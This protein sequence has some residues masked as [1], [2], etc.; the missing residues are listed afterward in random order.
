MKSATRNTLTPLSY[1]QE[2]LEFIDRFETGAVYESSPI[3][4]NIPLAVRFA[5]A[6]DADLLQQ[7]LDHIM[8][9]HKVLSTTFV[10]EGVRAFQ[11]RD[12]SLGVSLQIRELAAE[13]PG[14]DE[15]Q[16]LRLVLEE[17]EV[18]FVLVSRPMIRATLFRRAQ[19]E[20]LLVLVAHHIIVDRFSMRL[21]VEE[22][23]EIYDSLSSG[24]SPNLS[25]AGLPYSDYAEWQQG[26]AAKD[27][28][29]Y[30]MYWKNRLGGE[31]VDL[32]L[33]VRCPRHAMHIY[34]GAVHRFSIPADLAQAAQRLSARYQ[35]GAFEFLFACFYALLHRYSAQE[36]FLVGITDPCRG[37]P[38]TENAIGPF[39]NLLALDVKAGAGAFEE[40]LTSAVTNVRLA[41][42][43]RELPFDLLVQRLKLTNDM[44]RTAL[45]DV[46]FHYEDATAPILTF[47]TLRGKILETNLG[48][49]KYD[50]NL[51]LQPGAVGLSA[52][53]AYN[54]LLYNQSTIEQLARHFLSL[55]VAAVNAPGIP[56]GAVAL[57]NEAERTQQIYGWNSTTAGYPREKTIH[58]LIEERVCSQPNE[59]ALKYGDH[60]LTFAELNARANQLAHWLRKQGVGPD[61]MVA[62]CLERTLEMVVA[63]LA[64]L[65][66]G[67]GYLPLD[68]LYPEE[69]MRFIMED[70]Q[71][72]HLITQETLATRL[73]GRVRFITLVDKDQPEI[74]AQATANVVPS[75]RPANLAYCIYTSGST[76]KPNGVLIEH[77]QVV[78]LIKNDRFYF[79]FRSSDV[80]TLFHS[81]CFDF[82]VWE[83]FCSLSYG[84]TLVIVPREIAR[85][86]RLFLELLQ[87]ERVTVLNQTPA[88][89]YN[90]AA[91]AQQHPALDLALRYVI[92]G[93]EALQPAYLKQWK[94]ICPDSKLINMYGITETTVHVT[95]REVTPLD[96]EENTSNIGVPIPTT[97]TYILDAQMELAP[98]G[99]K[100]EIY[101]GGAGLARGYLNRSGLTAAR[102]VP[103][104]LNQVNGPR[105]YR[106]GDLAR[107]LSDGSIEYLGRIDHQVKLRGYRI[108]LGEIETAL[109]EL[110]GVERA[111]VQLREDS[112]GQKHLVAYV[113]AKDKKGRLEI[114]RL[115]RQLREK[116]PEYMAPG[117]FMELASVPLTP[118]GKV[119]HKRLPQPQ[120]N[121]QESEFAEPRNVQEEILCGIFAEILKRERVGVHDNF[122]E[123]G[124]HSLLATPVI[125][126]I[127]DVFKVE[128]PLRTL[129]EGPTVAALS[130]YIDRH[131]GNILEA[132]PIKRVSREGRLPLSFAQERLWFLDQLEPGSAAYNMPFGVRLRGELNEEALRRSVNEIVRRHEALRTSFVLEEG[133]PAQKIGA[134]LEV[135][136]EAINLQGMGDSGELEAGRLARAM[137]GEGFDLGRGPLLQI[138]L[139]RLGEEEHVLLVNMHHIVSDGWSSVIMVREF[140]RLYE[141]YVKG[142][143]SP[144]AELEVQ[145]VDYAVWQ[146]GWLEGE[147][148]E[149]QMGYWRE[150][151]RGLEALELPT[152]YAR[153]AVMSQRGGS[154]ELQLSAPLT[155]KLKELGRRQGATLFMSL[156]GGMQ[157]MLSKYV[158]QHDLAVG[159]VIANRNRTE[160]EGLIGFFVNTLVLRTDLGGNPDFREALKRVRHVALEAY[161]HQDMPFEKLVEE[162]S[163]Q[164]DL[165]RSPLFQVMLVLQNMEQQELQLTGLQVSGFEIGSEAA[166]FDLLL[167]L[168][169]QAG[170]VKGRL[171]YA[172]DLYDETTIERMAGHLRVVLEAMAGSARQKVGSID[173]LGEQE[174]RQILDEW[175][176][177]ERALPRQSVHE[178]FAAQVVRTPAACALSFEGQRLSY[179]ELNRRSSGLA[180]C[181]C[182]MGVGIETRVGLCL[183]RSA[184]MVIGILGI[185]KAGGVYVPLDPDYPA[186]RLSYMLEDS[187]AGVLLLGEGMWEKHAT[188]WAEYK[189]HVL[190][191]KDVAWSSDSAAQGFETGMAVQPE[192]AAYVIYTSGSTGRPKGVVVT[193]GNVARLMEGTERW[194]GFN[195]KDVIPLFHSYGFDFSVWEM[196]SALHYGGRLVVTSYWVSR[197][198]EEFV[199]LLIGEEVTVLNQTPSAFQQLMAAEAALGREWNG[200]GDARLKLR[201]VIFGGEALDYA[202]LRPW[203]ERHGERP[204]LV[205]MYGITETTVHVTYGPIGR[206]KVEEKSVRSAIGAP[207][208]DLKV[209]LLDERRQAAPVGVRGELYVGGAGVARGYLN[210]PE[211]TAER[212]VPNPYAKEAGERLYC[213]GDA[214]SWRTDGS[215]DYYGRL[216]QQVKIRGFRIELGEIEARL[217]EHEGVRE[218]VVVA[219]EDTSGEKRL[220]AYYTPSPVHAFPVVQLLRLRK[221]GAGAAANYCTLPNGL[222]VFHQNQSETD[223]VYDEIFNGD[224]YLRYGVTLNDGDCVFDVGA[225]IGLFSLFVG[226]RCRNATIYAFEPIPPVF[227]SLR[228][229]SRLHGWA[230]KLYECGLAETSKQ[231]VFTFYPHNT[232]ISSSSTN[233]KSYLLKQQEGA[234]VTNGRTV[235]DEGI[236]ELLEARLKSEEYMCQLR[237]VSEIIEENG[238][239]RIDLLKIN[240][241][242]SEHDVLKGIED[243]DWPKIRQLVIEVHDVSGRLGEIV[244]LFEARGYK[245]S[246]EQSRF[247]QHTSLYSLYACRP[248]IGKGASNGNGAG[249]RADA[250]KFWGSPESLLRDMRAFLR[251][252]LPEYMVP[253]AYVP[254]D[255]MPLTANGKLDRKALPAPERESYGQ[256]DEDP[257]G[258]VEKALAEIW[259]TVLQVERVGRHDNFFE[260]GGHSLLAITL[261]ERMRRN[262]LHA[263]VRTLFTTPTLADLAAAIG[264]ASEEVEVPPNRIPAQAEI[265]TPEMLPLVQLTA[266]EIERIVSGVVGG[267]SNV[268]DIYPLA[269]LQEGILFHHLIPAEGDTYLLLGLYGFDTRVRLE[270][271]VSALQ[272]VIDRHD[273]LRTAVVWEGLPEPVQVVWRKAPLIVEEVMF[274]PDMGD[275]AQQMYERF[276]PSRNRIDVRQA[277]LMRAYISHDKVGQRWL[278]LIMLHHLSGDH[279]T[280]EVM[281]SEIQAH[282]QG[283]VDALPAPLPFRNF[284]AQARM[285]VSEEEHKAFFRNMLEDV[286]EPTAPFGLL[287]IKGGDGSKI[288]QYY[289][290][291]EAGLALRL[292]EHARSLGVSV[293]SIFHVAWTLVLARVSGRDDVVFGTVLFGRMQGGEGADRV[294]GLFINTL[295]LRVRVGMEGV[296]ASVRRMHAGLADLIQHEHASLVLAQRCSG[297]AAPT[298]LFSAVLNY[299]YN[300]EAGQVSSG[301]T[302]N[303]WAGVELLHSVERNNYPLTLSVEDLGTDL[304]LSVLVDPL[305]EPMRICAFMHVALERLVEALETVPAQPLRSL[306]ALPMSERR[307]IVEEWNAT[308]QEYE[309]DPCLHELFERQVERTPESVAV[310]YAGQELTYGELDRRANQLGHYLRRMG[311]GPEV[312]VGICVERSLEMVVGMLGILKAGGAYVAL[313]PGYPGERLGY[314]LGDSGASV[315]VTQERLAGQLL[316]K[317]TGQ[318]RQVAVVCLDQEWEEKIGKESGR[319]LEG[320]VG[321]E[322]LSYIYY[323]SGSTGRPKGVAMA[324]RGIVNYMRWG[325]EGYRAREGRGAGVHSSIAVDLTLTNFLPLFVGQRMALAPEGPG[326]EGL[327]EVMK[328]EPGWSLLKITPTHLTLLNPRLTEREMRNS[329]RVLVIGAD[330]LVAEPTLVWREKAPGVMLLNEYG[331]TETVVGCSVYRIGGDAPRRGGMPIGKPIWNMTMYVL[332][333]EG[334]PAPVGVA[335]ELYIG[336]VGVARGYWGKPELTAE[337]FV[338][339]RYAGMGARFYRTGDRARFLRDGNL[340]FLGRVDHQ[341]KIRGY[342]IE[343]E[344]IEAVISGCAGVHKAMVVVREDEPGEKRLVGYVA[345][346]GGVE[347]KELREYLKE[348]LPDYMIPVAFVVLEE[349]PVR[350][351]G[352][353]DPKDLPRPEMVG[354]E[355]S[356]VEARTE[357]ER[358]LARIWEEVLGVERVGVHDNFFELG[359]DSILSLRVTTRAQGEGIQL[360]PLHMFERQTI[361]ELAQVVGSESQQ[362][363]VPQEIV[364]GA[365]ELTP[366]QAAFFEK[367]LAKP[368]HHNQTVLLELREEVS[369]ELLEQLVARLLDQHDGLRMRYKRSENGWQQ[370]YEAQ[371]PAGVYERKMLRTSEEEDWAEM[372]QDIARVQADLDLEAGRLVKVVEYELGAG[373]GKRL[374]LVVHHLLMDEASWRILLEDLERGYEQFKEGQEINLGTKTSS[375]KQWAEW[376]KEQ[377]A[378][379]E[380]RQEMEYWGAEARTR[381]AKRLPWDYEA[382]PEE[383]LYET[384]RMVEVEL[385][386]QEARSLLQDVPGV[387]RTELHEVL[388]AVLGKVCG[389]WTGSDSVL[390]DVEGHGRENVVDGL[391]LSRTIGRFTYMYPLVFEGTDRHGEWK[392]GEALAFVKEDLRAIP[393]HGLG[394]G[395]L[396][397]MSGDE[398]IQQDLKEL[399]QAEISFNYLEMADPVFPESSWFK[400]A[401]EDFVMPTASKNQRPYALEFTAVLSGARLRVNWKYSEK[402]HRRDSIERIA[403][404]YMEILRELIVHCRNEQAGG[405]TPSDFPLARMSAKDLDELAA[406]LD[407]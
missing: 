292:R 375:F 302:E 89:F 293:A 38:G 42:K 364:T 154:V 338:P 232:A 349:L 199:E 54:S 133:E 5:G 148:L 39:S 387:Y 55:M 92:F 189:G 40:F 392:P 124:G 399:P 126:R 9:R 77:S 108:E 347:V 378:T 48:Y 357:V 272:S 324:H 335:G 32:E 194:F 241:E 107:Y 26:L 84:A 260:L 143:E 67:G 278:L 294:M 98:V 114:S 59:I 289:L 322:N 87:R 13:A 164:R 382:S 79:D 24:R 388:L 170:M 65:K 160:T 228:L 346:P 400:L 321:A 277:P 218:A 351:S 328:G 140:S 184:E 149:Q 91:Q 317:A 93:G 29:P 129:F 115:R 117:V 201:L 307:Q 196:W 132:V 111:V 334:E 61:T 123:L 103:N 222:T 353:I 267:A 316:G 391:D 180:A 74:A 352:K 188:A 304:S 3:Y 177:A 326:V 248:A 158:R 200:R 268:Q 19:K 236:D 156:M 287:D 208:P 217:M 380:V 264:T 12:E 31:R 211:L 118:N 137:A 213:S 192:N 36:R 369:S 18:P 256:G 147:V 45:F 202:S 365:V 47:G 2:R 86:S 282:V 176:R 340:E 52:T 76:G 155:Q 136:I 203:V 66:S 134:E 329:T 269:P 255:E 261:I 27:W 122:F 384:Q 254:L 50:L 381:R 330:N 182:K 221:T 99:V 235:A 246:Y 229:N 270:T 157:I 161:R 119:D 58:Q 63:A 191:W 220:V 344:E 247:L 216:D 43:H 308:A 290:K 404:R 266:V 25:E 371:A 210:R 141:A 362:V 253:T 81:Y 166:Q 23:A 279:I 20:S 358:V 223:F 219:R 120:S 363:M 303:A 174:R 305:I 109:V 403:G 359:G 402:L 288:A 262:G 110:E 151:L 257:V 297:V 379:P 113:V 94:E 168:S 300:A 190:E 105:I 276:H 17:V 356:Y 212:F 97:T 186:E 68:P 339:D 187:Q 238:I 233:R 263:N 15:E 237:T 150:Q 37:M 331:P 8:K 396:R 398:K 333:G 310:E 348:R 361:A 312:R 389:E 258:R 75:S 142:E 49:G 401:A 35:G 56:V 112:A 366:V 1:H 299:R 283:R 33:P 407:E 397:Y 90:L 390:I 372:A 60:Q 7:S 273:I 386:E 341:V 301:E 205:N 405:Y 251:E 78:R 57:L 284:V 325:V 125:S 46:V 197:S 226:Q 242:K 231:Q 286:I 206:E 172:R 274:D 332:D 69:R 383:N 10:L 367:N 169:E 30:W 128:P 214:A 181:L 195:E 106:T 4:H 11:A 323:T 130:L 185:L 368:Q 95:F 318:A 285:G 215:L 313:D 265:I 354:E 127:R 193:H 152:D 139:L 243:C 225:N 360:T 207:L 315:V 395:V 385:E 250:E 295:P 245:V 345:A 116:L 336:G 16:T 393:S 259:K 104:S 83:M 204:Q 306:D 145:Y 406:L 209:Y 281:H 239:E 198:A 311:V 252:R 71:V 342:R 100:G 296:E 173:L 171:S 14:F 249:N 337:R 162:L 244:A 62:V 28:D 53:L 101:V 73:S 327:V 377:G 131:E 153:P 179:D 165:S 234:D 376:L 146:R 291:I 159:T 70:A 227:D 394:Y 319:S 314:M 88:S 82:S 144:L 44:S 51:L 224:G 96:I 6:I 320:E 183:E 72:V 275:G 271:Y 374:L 21:I 350:S 309:D 298:P 64:V 80:W 167:T 343:L 85:D 230:G 373:R 135:E 22:L 175:T 240:V 34:K 138:K 121:L 355:E 280:M 370:W 102:F 178:R 41:R 163:P